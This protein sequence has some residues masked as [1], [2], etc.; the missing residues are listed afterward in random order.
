MNSTFLKSIVPTTEVELNMQVIIIRK[1]W[2]KALKYKKDEKLKSKL[3]Q[4]FVQR[5]HLQRDSE[6]IEWHYG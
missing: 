3:H 6:A 2:L 5:C 4:S 1:Q